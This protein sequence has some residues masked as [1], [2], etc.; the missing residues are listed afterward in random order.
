MSLAS[1]GA[2]RLVGA[3]LG[4]DHVAIRTLDIAAVRHVVRVV[5]AHFR[6]SIAEEVDGVAGQPL[7]HRRRQPL[8]GSGG[9]N[10]MRR[11]DDDQVGF[12]LLIVRAAEQGTEYGHR[13]EPR[14]LAAISR[15]I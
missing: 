5:L 7:V 2:R 12:A 1:P 15:I 6:L 10:Q 8:A 9:L 14:Y 11:D 3:G 4:A 13:T